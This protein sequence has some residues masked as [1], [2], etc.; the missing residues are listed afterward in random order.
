MKV[1]IDGILGSAR[2]INNQRQVG[3]DGVGKDRKEVKADSVSIGNRINSRLDTIEAELRQIQS[4]LTRNQTIRAGIDELRADLASDGARQEA[5]L[6]ETTFEGEE[7]L[8]NFIGGSIDEKSL[9]A[10]GKSIGEAILGDATQLKRL[11]VEVD[12]LMASNLAGSDRG[13]SLMANIDSVVSG[14]DSANSESLSSLRHDTVM[15]LIK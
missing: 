7:V 5:I 4:S 11:Q 8:Q 14:I 9:E 12:N 6:R 2:K 13:E 1:S 3:K 15:K 10:H